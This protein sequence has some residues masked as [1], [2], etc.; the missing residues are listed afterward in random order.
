MI[1]EGRG[2]K[3]YVRLIILCYKYNIFRDMMVF[4]NSVSDKA[5]TLNNMKT[6][7]KNH[8]SCRLS[9]K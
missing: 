7:K 4:V 8:L 9:R 1:L 2:R 5:K 3:A 6:A